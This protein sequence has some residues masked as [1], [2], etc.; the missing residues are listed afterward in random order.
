[1]IITYTR[2]VNFICTC[3]L[4]IKERY[5]LFLKRYICKSNFSNNVKKYDALIINK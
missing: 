2:N 4:N 3:V 5:I 1:M